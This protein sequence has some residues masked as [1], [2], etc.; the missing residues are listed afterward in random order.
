[1]IHH[2]W[3]VKGGYETLEKGVLVS[4]DFSNAFPT[5]A[6]NFIQA[7]L[8]FIQLPPFHVMF[9]LST[10]TTPYHFC[11]GRG[12]VSEVTFQPRAG[13]GQGDPLP[14]PFL[15]SFCASFVLFMFDELVGAYP[16]MYV[17]DLCVLV[18]SRCTPN[19]K[20]ILDAMH[21]FSKS[22]GLKLN[23]GKSALILKRNFFQQPRAYFAS[24][25]LSI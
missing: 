14:P 17:D 5:L 7:V 21:Q 13:I 2:F 3:G 25:G 15:F 4:F 12:I 8:H 9:I 23:L 1:M 24:C 11:A 16:F 22:L 20:H 10:L 6:H 18:S 19:L